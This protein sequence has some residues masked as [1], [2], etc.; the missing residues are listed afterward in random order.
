GHWTAQHAIEIFR[1]CRV[2]Q[3]APFLL[4]RQIRNQPGRTVTNVEQLVNTGT[5]HV[6]VD[7]QYP[8]PQLRQR[9]GQVTSN[10]GFA[11]PR[12]RTDE[13]QRPGRSPSRRQQHRGS[14]AAEGFG[15][16]RML[17]SIPVNTDPTSFYLLSQMGQPTVS[18]RRCQTNLGEL[19]DAV[20]AGIEG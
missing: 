6:R 12:L 14:Q 8:L 3:V 18:T 16:R 15:Q 1:S 5:T 20:P 19:I 11:L 13:S 7:Q 10:G 4:P 17:C 9:D 2:N